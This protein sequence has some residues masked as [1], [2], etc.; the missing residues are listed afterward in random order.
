M[1][2]RDALLAKGL[3]S[4]KRAQEVDRELK[5]ER[6]A[7]Q[8]SR[9]RKHAAEVEQA[10]AAKAAAE[11]ER[12]ERSAQRQAS[13]EAR[14][15]HEL[16]YRVRQLV[17]DNALGGRGPIPFHHRV[18]TTPRVGTVYVSEAMGRELRAG[19]AAIAGY[20]DDGGAWVHKVITT[21]GAE[22]LEAIA[23]EAV[24]HWVR[25]GG[26]LHDPAEALLRRDWEPDLRARRVRSTEAA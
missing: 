13:T 25:D 22:K 8:G 18:G 12:A 4:K 15:R 16:R 11:A 19:R 17:V 5:A 3:V 23:P 21:R 9:K 14:D 10:A 26:H 1:S 24:A 20:V 6:K 7:Q 2:L